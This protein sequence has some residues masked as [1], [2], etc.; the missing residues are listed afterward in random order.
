MKSLRHAHVAVVA[1][2]E[3]ALTLAQRLAAMEQITVTA[4]A[5]LDEAT[6]LCRAGRVDVCLVAYR[7]PML[8]APPR[9]HPDAPGRDYGVPSLLI[10]PAL[11]TY[12]RT[13]ACRAGY[14]AAVPVGILPRLLYRQIGAVLQRGRAIGRGR[15]HLPGSVVP[16]PPRPPAIAKPTLH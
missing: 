4:V 5:D 1:D 16:L 8:D 6:R 15:R 10:V 3:Q 9:P 13:Y 14:R 2:S 11:T 12:L 7:V